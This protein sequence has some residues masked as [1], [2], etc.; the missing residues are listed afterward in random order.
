MFFVVS[1]TD[2]PPQALKANETITVDFPSPS[3]I[4]SAPL[5]EDPL[6]DVQPQGGVPGPQNNCDT[7]FGFFKDGYRYD[8]W[9][10]RALTWSEAQENCV[11]SGGELA[12]HGLDNL[13][14]RM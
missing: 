11:R 3:P 6:Q 8:L 13:E 4:P 1:L 14:T 5:V 2:T 12:Y 7:M 10:R 9:P